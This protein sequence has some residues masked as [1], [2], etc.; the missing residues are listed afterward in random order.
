[1]AMLRSPNVLR[2]AAFSVGANGGNPAGVVFV[3][4]FPSDADMLALAAHIGYSETAFIRAHKDAFFVRYFAPTLE[5]PFCGHA[6]VASLAALGQRFGAGRFLLQTA[7]GPVTGTAAEAD[8][9]TWRGGFDA[10]RATS[11][12][13]PPAITATV[14]RAFGINDTDL[15][16]QL[17]PAL[18]MAG[19]RHLQLGLASR[20]R[21]AAMDYDM[22]AMGAF[23]RAHDIV[24]VNLLWRED[25]A[26]FH[27]RNAFASGGVFEDPATGAAAAA[28]GGYL[29]ERGQT[30]RVVVL[31]GEDM[32]QPCR[33]EVDLA[34]AESPV[35]VA[36]TVT[37]VVSA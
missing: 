37:S 28:L 11:T 18:V 21:L 13:V 12:D 1:M 7:A 2:L 34:S 23:M 9:D 8:G 14:L 29:R 3:D 16:R 5:V 36:G 31:Q 35:H 15:D 25:Q 6:T 22:T 33:I 17:G 20:E 27:S 26:T 19:A 10:P 24:T 32:G 30:G 4:E